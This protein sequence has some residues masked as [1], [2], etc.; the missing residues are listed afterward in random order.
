MHKHGVWLALGHSLKLGKFRMAGVFGVVAALVGCALLGESSHGTAIRESRQASHARTPDF[1]VVV[2]ALDGVRWQDVFEGTDPG[3]A[4]SHGMPSTEHRSAAELMPNLHALIAQGAL[5]FGAPEQPIAASGPNYKSLPGYTEILGGRRASHCLDN[6]CKGAD[7]PTV[8]DECARLSEADPFA[9]A[10]IT[11]WADIERVAALEPNRVALSTGRHGGRTRALLTHDKASRALVEEAE[12]QEPY[13]G[14]ADFRPDA[15]TAR[16]ALQYLK[17]Q[18]P[19]LLFLGLGEPDEYAHRNDYR[20]YLASLRESD[21][22]IGEVARALA[23]RERAGAR[24]AL[25]VTTDHGRARN[26]TDHGDKYPESAR[27]WLVA[28]G[29]EIA[30]GA[31][32]AP[33]SDRRLADIAPTLRYLLGMPADHHPLAGASLLS[34]AS[35]LALARASLLA[36]ATQSASSR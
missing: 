8:L 32:V 10:A 9:C 7:V 11:S 17:K 35:P 34:S 23:E 2:V 27:V 33:R 18:R 31:T 15:F 20:A 24:T 25:F 4:Q 36:S 19:R 28:S 3:L 14:H 6:D 16:I 5:A 12:R 22:T 1:A 30:K 29:S 26:F 21:R 13:P